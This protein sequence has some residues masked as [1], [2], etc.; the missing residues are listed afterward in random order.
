MSRAKLQV[1]FTIRSGAPTSPHTPFCSTKLERLSSVKKIRIDEDK[2][3]AKSGQRDLANCRSNHV[4][5]RLLFDVPSDP[6]KQQTRVVSGHFLGDQWV[7]KIMHLRNKVV[8]TQSP[9]WVS[10]NAIAP[11]F[12]PCSRKMSGQVKTRERDFL[13]A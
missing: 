3:I 11:D 12:W 7:P 1:C 4:F 6:P 9:R 2:R 8:A 10:S 13:C 5:R